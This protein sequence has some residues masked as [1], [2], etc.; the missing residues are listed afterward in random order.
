MR[1]A[2]YIKKRAQTDAQAAE[3]AVQNNVERE[4]MAEALGI[5]GVETEEGADES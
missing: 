3:E 2:E 4:T 5:L 1:L